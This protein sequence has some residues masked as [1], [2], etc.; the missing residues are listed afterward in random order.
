MHSRDFLF[1]EFCRGGSR[2]TMMLHQ[3][4][5][6]I[7]H[8]HVESPLHVKSPCFFERQATRN[9]P[10]ISRPAER[11]RMIV[12]PAAVLVQINA[13][14]VRLVRDHERVEDGRVTFG[15]VVRWIVIIEQS[16]GIS[17]AAERAP[18][19]GHCTEQSSASLH[20]TV[21]PEGILDAG[22]S[23]Q[24]FSTVQQLSQERE[25]SFRVLERGSFFFAHALEEVALHA[26]HKLRR[27]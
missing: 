3:L 14:A 13:V 7:P 11:R 21:A 15:D 1:H 5:P 16:Y 23:T 24:L 18:V 19:A 22:K 12:N 9:D 2:V 4:R 26:A 20:D 10:T 8:S 25:E 27:K 6:A 17:L